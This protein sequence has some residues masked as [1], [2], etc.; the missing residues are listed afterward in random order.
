MERLVGWCR[1]GQ[2]F[3]PGT[4]RLM[5][6]HHGRC[7]DIL[8]CIVIVGEPYVDGAKHHKQG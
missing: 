1:K 2:R 3:Y 6:V 7:P 8:K 5:L 4:A